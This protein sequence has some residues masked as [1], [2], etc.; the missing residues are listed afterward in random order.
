MSYI[1]DGRTSSSRGGVVQRMDRQQ[2]E[3]KDRP[4][5]VGVDVGRGVLTGSQMFQGLILGLRWFKH[6]SAI[7]AAFLALT[8]VTTPGV[9][10]SSAG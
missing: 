1:H 8:V 6:L 2:L 9:M 3:R 10:P 5:R 4:Q 7:A